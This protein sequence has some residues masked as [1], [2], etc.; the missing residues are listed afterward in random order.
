MRATLPLTTQEQAHVRTALRYFRT[1]F[2]SWVTVARAVHA[3]RATLRR[4]RGGG[5]VRLYLA[6]RVAIL[7]AISLVDLREGRFPRAWT[8]PVCGHNV[9]VQNLVAVP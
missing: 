9:A 5:R 1:R 2:G 4:I 8:C 7:A 3:K 6:R